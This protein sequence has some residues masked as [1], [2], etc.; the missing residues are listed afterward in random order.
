MRLDSEFLFVQ[1]KEWTVASSSATSL[2]HNSREIWLKLQLC[3]Y[4][5]PFPFHIIDPQNGA[6]TKS[7]V[8]YMN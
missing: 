2:R 5:I 6:F 7:W 8:L 1:N 3:N 4:S